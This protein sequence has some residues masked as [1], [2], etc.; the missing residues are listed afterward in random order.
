V[1]DHFHDRTFRQ[2]LTVLG[3]MYAGYGAMMICRQ[4]VTILSPALLA[5]ESLNFTVKHTGDILAYG[6]VGAMVGK[7]IWGPL[8]DKIGG[9]LTFLIGIVLTALLVAT[10]GLSQNV[11][12][13][14]VCSALLYCTKS[15]GW[16][17]MTKIVGNWYRPR[18]YGRV[19]SILSTSSRASVVLGTLFFGWLLAFFDWR[20]VAF[21]AAAMALIV[22]AVCRF[23]LQD[24]PTD[25]DFL[26][27]DKEIT[28]AFADK[29][30]HPLDGTSLWGG[31]RAFTGS[32]RVW[33]VIAMLMALTC[34][35]AFLDFLP[36]YLM[37]NFQLKP[38]QASMASFFMPLGS[39]IGLVVSI[40]CYD[41]FSRQQLRAVLTATLAVATLCI[42]CLQF[43]PQLG[44]SSAWNFRIAMGLILLFGVTT[45]P[46]YYIPMSIFSIEFGGPHSATLVCLIDMFG[47]AASASFGFL[48]G[49]L[50]AGTGGWT[51]FM[52][53]LIGVGV[54]AT[55]STWLF[56]NGEYK[57][58]SRGD[59]S[60]DT[61]S[62]A[63]QK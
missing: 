50:A 23:F 3:S 36:A 19:W 27:D 33:C 14:T 52:T 17:G 44:I 7:L 2:Q 13:F 18:Q 55:I 51:S 57:A 60:P 34:A 26:N 11:M 46:A 45:S 25:P 59:V 5:D 32:I 28:A 20:T 16:P 49:R 1:K 42:V 12:A 22:Y 53:M 24:K 61:R 41:W 30:T 29:R 37:E 63:N 10:F 39:L 58:A 9:R 62:R 38:Y 56:L 47:F 6:T 43:L 21:L 8:A 35:M 4:M 40:V 31:L 48:G 15:S 54:V